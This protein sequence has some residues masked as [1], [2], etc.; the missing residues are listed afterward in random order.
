MANKQ[1]FTKAI[2]KKKKK[3]DSKGK[4][5]Y[6]T[7]KSKIFLLAFLASQRIRIA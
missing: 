3:S 6:T 1:V 2:C 5:I 4:D 7:L